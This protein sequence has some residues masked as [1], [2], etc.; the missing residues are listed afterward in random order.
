MTLAEDAEAVLAASL[1]YESLTAAGRSAWLDAVER[2]SDGLATPKL[3]LYAPLLFVERDAKRRARMLEAL[4]ASGSSPATACG[5]AH[6]D[7]SGSCGRDCSG[8]RSALRGDLKGDRIA[9]V[10]LS[11]LYLSFGELL[12]VELDSSG[13]IQTAE[14]NALTH[15]ERWTPPS[16]VTLAA[17]P[18]ADITEALAHAILE[19]RRTG[20]MIPEAL[21][22]ASHLL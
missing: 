18:V 20:R 16:G 7:A 5:K 15:L 19:Q 11:R 22:R 17:A 10:L 4:D 12:Y 8:S 1:T 3:A 2:D 14:L 9:L 21:K 13:G 6:G